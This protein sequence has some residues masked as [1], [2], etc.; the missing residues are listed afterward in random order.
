MLDKIE[1]D[2][3]NDVKLSKEAFKDLNTQL[4]N[5]SSRRI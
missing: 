5:N 3:D 1:D 2:I 4:K